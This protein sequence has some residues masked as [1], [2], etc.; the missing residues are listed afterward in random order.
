MNILIF[1]QVTYPEAQRKEANRAIHEAPTHTYHTFFAKRPLLAAT[2]KV[3]RPH[4]AHEKQHLSPNH[5]SKTPMTPELSK[6]AR[7]DAIA[8][9][10]RYCRE[11]LSEPLGD[12]AAGLLLNFFLREI[13]PV[14]YNRAIA[15]AQARLQ[16]HAAE[17]HGELYADE[18]TYW[19]KTENKR[20]RP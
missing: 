9:L 4:P 3:G 14:I 10:Q 7:A 11:N 16:Q 19:M 6:Q 8:S 5:W 1:S 2:M 17:L 15:D 12:L 20:R 13:A 18:F